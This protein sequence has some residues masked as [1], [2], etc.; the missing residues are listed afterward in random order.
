[1]KIL[2]VAMLLVLPT[3]AQIALTSPKIVLQGTCSGTESDPNDLSAIPDTP[4]IKCD[5]AVLTKADGHTTVTFSDGLAFTGDL[6]GVSG[7]SQPSN[8][9]IGPIATY[10]YIGSVLWGDGTPLQH[11]TGDTQANR[12]CYF[13]YLGDRLT[14][15]ECELIVENASH[16]RRR[17]T[18]TFTVK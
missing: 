5:Y 1:M 4:E 11:V 17:A 6:A 14:E 7:I 15:I 13:H 2:L 8:P 16:R 9:Q 10:F 3:G 18:V 12:G